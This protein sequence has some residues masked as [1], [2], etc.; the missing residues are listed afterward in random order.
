[1]TIAVSIHSYLHH[2]HG[3]LIHLSIETDWLKNA[4]EGASN[5]TKANDNAHITQERFDM[6]SDFD[7]PRRIVIDDTDARISYEGEP[8]VLDIGSFDNVGI[9]GAPYNHTSHGTNKD[10]ASLSFTFEV[11]CYDLREVVS[12]YLRSSSGDQRQPCVQLQGR[13]PFD[14]INALAKWACHV[15]GIQIPSQPYLQEFNFITDRV[16]CEKGGLAPE[17]LHTLSVEA[18]IDDPGTQVF[19]VDR[20]EYA[21]LPNAS[22]D[23]VVLKIDG[24]DS[25]LRYSNASGEWAP[26][27]SLGYGTNWND[28]NLSFKFNGTSAALY[29]FNEGSEYNWRA[30][31]G[32]YRID[33]DTQPTAF[34]IEGSRKDPMKGI[35]TDFCN[36]LHFTTPNLDSGLHEMAV[37]YTGTPQQTGG[38]PPEWLTIDYL[39]VTTGDSTKLNSSVTTPTEALPSQTSNGTGSSP[40]KVPVGAIVGGIFGGIA[41]L[42]LLA[43]SAFFFLRRRKAR[44]ERFIIDPLDLPDSDAPLLQN[45]ALPAGVA[46]TNLEGG[47]VTISHRPAGT[48]LAEREAALRHGPEVVERRSQDSG[49][50]YNQRVMDDVPP[51]YTEQ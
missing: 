51:D 14:D 13:I 17:S 44:Q 21:P 29:G 46:S 32:Q 35:Q 47:R 4:V 45:A 50:R 18:V 33:N 25:S 31:T 16:L 42:A 23:N 2:V 6:Q 22:L 40:K 36:V 5:L 7:Y 48:K 43:L 28:A 30:S 24:S 41:G 26:V 39:Y 15:D 12:R 38:D 27:G 34:G 3:S 1:M 49:I 8:W 9:F 19:W 11:P 10:G 37:T 20:I